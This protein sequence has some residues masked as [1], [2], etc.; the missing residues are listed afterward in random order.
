VGAGHAAFLIV[1]LALISEVAGAPT[2]ARGISTD[3]WTPFT[4]IA[5]FFA[6]SGALHGSF[7]IGYIAMGL[8]LL[9]VTSLVTGLLGAWW[10]YICMGPAGPMWLAFGLGAAYG[11]FIEVVGMQAIVNPL[12][13]PDVVYHSAPPWSWWAGVGIFGGVV[14]MVALGRM[15]REAT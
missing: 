4:G 11:L 5:S 3:T 14:G 6:G 9:V 2:T 1:H 15:G 7:S 12:Q 10:V 13:S 8:G